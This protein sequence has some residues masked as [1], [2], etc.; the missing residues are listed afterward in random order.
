[1]DL[2]DM[3]IGELAY[4][5]AV[6][7]NDV[8]LKTYVS[9]ITNRDK[10]NPWSVWTESYHLPFTGR[11]AGA[12]D[13]EEIDSNT[14][15]SFHIP[16]FLAGKAHEASG[17]RFLGGTIFVSKSNDFGTLQKDVDLYDEVSS[18][19]DMCVVYIKR[20][21]ALNYTEATP[22]QNVR[23]DRNFNRLPNSNDPAL[24]YAQLGK[25]E[26]FLMTPRLYRNDPDLSCLSIGIPVDSAYLKQ[27]DYWYMFMEPV[28]SKGNS[29]IVGWKDV[30]V[31]LR[32]A[33][34][35]EA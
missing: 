29:S 22:P 14:V 28:D 27:G 4:S 16:V 35:L 5:S 21:S 25:N 24:F 34:L 3:A 17:R 32:F 15:N 7:N 2:E 33:A 26:D 13:I 6:Y 20:T 23:Y 30:T 12:E 11:I 8:K 18:D 1:M 10:V 19:G 31:T 9:N